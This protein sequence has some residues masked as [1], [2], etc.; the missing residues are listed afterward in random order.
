MGR[1]KVGI[2]PHRFQFACAAAFGRG[3]GGDIDAG[4]IVRAAVIGVRHCVARAR[5]IIDRFA[6]AGDFYDLHTLE[7]RGIGILD[8]PG[9]EAWRITGADE[10]ATHRHAASIGLP[11]EIRRI[12]HVRRV[13]KAA[14]ET[15]LHAGASGSKR[16]LAAE[17]IEDGIARIFLCP[18][19]RQ[20]R[21]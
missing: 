10:I 9:N 21:C 14:E 20:A 19:A 2:G 3:A 13:T 4:A 18:N 17:R 6:A 5:G 16:F 11:G 7:R 1:V 8:G 12:Q 15:H